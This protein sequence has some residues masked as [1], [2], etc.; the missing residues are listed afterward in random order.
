V[1]DLNNI[2]KLFHE[3]LENFEMPVRAELWDKVAA[4]AGIGKTVFWTGTKISAAVVV[5]LVT[6]ASLSWLVLDQNTESETTTVANITQHQPEDFNPG[7]AIEEDNVSLETNESVLNSAIQ[8]PRLSIDKQ[9]DNNSVAQTDLPNQPIP[10]GLLG[11]IVPDKAKDDDLDNQLE[12]A[13]NVI[14]TTTEPAVFTP[15][16]TEILNL[17]ILYAPE[18][19]AEK[20]LEQI[21]FPHQFVQVFSSSLAG[22]AGQFSVYSENLGSFKIEIRTRAGKLVYAS[23]DPN[24]VWRGEQMDGSEAPEGTYMYTIFSTTSSGESIKPQAGSVFLMRK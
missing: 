21:H 3:K 20:S 9:K 11:Y 17:D 5:G 7:G 15:A 13:D 8:K 16:P 10:S 14:Q 1:S 23:S 24:F 6:I 2:E 18:K 12:I 19:T 4:G 22:E